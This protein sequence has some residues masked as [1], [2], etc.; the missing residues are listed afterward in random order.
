MKIVKKACLTFK[1]EILTGLHI[2]GSQGTFGIGS[3]DSP[4]IKDPI[5]DQ[6][7]IP[8]SSL[9]GK[10]KALLVL[11]GVD[12]NDI[13]FGGLKNTSPTRT[14]FR[15]S[16]LSPKS[17]ELLKNRLGEGNFTEVKYETK[18]DPLRGTAADGSLRS[19]ERVPAGVIFDGEIIINAYEGDD[20]QQFIKKITDGLNLLGL[21]Y[22]GGSGSRG[23]GKVAVTG[24]E[25]KYV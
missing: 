10:V 16:F 25:T 11:T 2:G 15:D 4:I 18:I 9:K 24:I 14:I 20:I 7:I 12:E 23:Y 5:T 21:N 13:I 17:I 19:I 1:I 22:L 6:P 3:L 8:G